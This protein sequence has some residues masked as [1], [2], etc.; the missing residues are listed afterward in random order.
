V[1]P[2]NELIHRA[3][4]YLQ[5]HDPESYKEAL[6]FLY[7]NNPTLSIWKRIHEEDKFPQICCDELIKIDLDN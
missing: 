5:K 3:L 6:N 1:T 4:N 2:H 7:E